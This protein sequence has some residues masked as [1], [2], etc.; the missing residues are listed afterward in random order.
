MRPEWTDESAIPYDQ[1]W[2]DDKFWLPSLL[3]GK[4]FKAEFHFADDE[5]TII[6]QH[7]QTYSDSRDF[8]KSILRE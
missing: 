4:F 1:M 6:R 5:A 7:F 8:K 3:Q 2:T